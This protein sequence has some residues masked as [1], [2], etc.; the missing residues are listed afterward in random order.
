MPETT[1]AMESPEAI[2]AFLEIFRASRRPLSISIPRSGDIFTSYLLNVRHDE[3][4]IDQLMPAIGSQM[5]QPG[6]SIDIR[7]SH[8]GIVYLFSADHIAVA[9]DVKN[10]PYH[11]VSRPARIGHLEK[12]ASYRVQPKL[13]DRPLVNIAITAEQSYKARLEN[14]SASGAC[15][16]IRSTHA[17]PNL[18]DSLV[19]CEIQLANLEPLHCHA[20]VR[21][22]QHVAAFNESRLGVEFRQMPETNNRKLHQALMQLQR[23]NIRGY[24]GS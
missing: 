2:N 8:N 11:Q 14:I 21:H 15:L 3:L 19:R 20:L 10:L 18:I 17:T 6:Q 7:L 16:R 1:P 4:H 23:H 5:L 13:A 24:I 22:H 12:R 9:V